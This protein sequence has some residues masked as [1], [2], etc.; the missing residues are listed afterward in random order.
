MTAFACTWRPLLS[1]TTGHGVK[2]FTDYNTSFLRSTYPSKWQKHLPLFSN[3][4]TKIMQI[5][6]V[7]YVLLKCADKTIP[8]SWNTLAEKLILLFSP[9]QQYLVSLYQTLFTQYILVFKTWQVKGKFAPGLNL[10]PSH[11]GNGDWTYK[12]MH[13][14]SQY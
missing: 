11:E 8:S 5:H 2:G 10:L 9:L 6:S 7:T 14:L 12:S 4:C 1:D 13:S 3:T